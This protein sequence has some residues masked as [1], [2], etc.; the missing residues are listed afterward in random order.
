MMEEKMTE[1]SIP[2]F[3]AHLDLA[4]NALSFNRDL[5]L[6]LSDLCDAD[7]CYGD[8]PFRGH[9][10]ISLEELAA[11]NL[12]VC[13]ATLL[14]RSGPINAPPNVLRR[15]LDYAHPSIA[16][17]HAHGQLAYYRWLERSK[18][19]W[20][21]RTAS[22]LK[23][24]WNHPDTLGLIISFEGCDP[25]LD[26]EDLHHWYDLGVRAAGLT[27]YGKGQYAAGTDADGGL[28]RKGRDL[29]REFESLGIILDVTHL[30][31]ESMSD[32][33]ECYHGPLLA[34]H[35]NCR[36][37]VPGQRQ[38]SDQQIRDLLDRDAVIG[39]AF[40]AWMLYPGWVRGETDR[41]VVNLSA[42]IDHIDHICELAGDTKHIAIGSDLDGGFGTNQTPTGLNR[43]S[44]LQLIAGLLSARGYSPADV[45]NIFHYNWLD[46]FHRSLPQN[47]D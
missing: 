8:G 6:P 5:T 29:L 16:H 31:D 47:H 20:I 1:S 33:V 17:A 28:T 44:N 37:L 36:A 32:A 12:R 45:N 10:A 43:Y 30:S 21:I 40:D 14:A 46:F 11:A 26:I 23:D 4:W 42:A 3:D 24:H 2:L 15:E 18:Q 22:D 9:C 13:V 41:S 27:H 39:I 25:I 7:A 34:S 38:L 19:A 35:H